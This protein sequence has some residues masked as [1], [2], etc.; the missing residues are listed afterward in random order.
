MSDLKFIVLM[1]V[2]LKIAYCVCVTIAAIHFDRSGILW[3]YLLA[4]AFGYEYHSGKDDK[5]EKT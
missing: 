1:S 4:F 5:N 3:W 2:L